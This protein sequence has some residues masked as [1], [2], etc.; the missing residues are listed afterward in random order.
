MMAHPGSPACDHAPATQAI[1]LDTLRHLD[2]G[3]GLTDLAVPGLACAPRLCC[4]RP[5]FT[6]VLKRHRL[7]L[8]RFLPDQDSGH[9][10]R[11]RHAKRYSRRGR[12]F[13]YVSTL[14][15]ADTQCGFF[16]AAKIGR[17]QV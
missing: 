13:L 8:V 9:A 1:S 5:R 14:R 6:Y 4:T 12:F 10:E 17:A 11:F 15:Q 2:H 16:N 7:T 3:Y